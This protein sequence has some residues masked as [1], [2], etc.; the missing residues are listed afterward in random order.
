[1]VIK[2]LIERIRLHRIN[3]LGEKLTLILNENAGRLISWLVNCLTREGW[4][5]VHQSEMEE[6]LEQ[7]DR[8]EKNAQEAKEAAERMEAAAEEIAKLKK[9]SQQEFAKTFSEYLYGA[10]GQ[11]E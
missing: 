4:R 8:A 6:L 2:K 3:S 1:M 7:I 10:E 9:E 5:L 11:D